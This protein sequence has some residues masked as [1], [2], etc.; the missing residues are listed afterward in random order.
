MKYLGKYYE[1]AVKSINSTKNQIKIIFIK[2]T[3]IYKMKSFSGDKIYYKLLFPNFL[4][5][6]LNSCLYRYYLTVM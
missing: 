6:I 1:F 2:T 3:L 5:L 4:A